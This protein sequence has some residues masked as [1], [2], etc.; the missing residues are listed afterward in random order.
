MK[1]LLQRVR[2][3]AVEVDGERIADIGAGIVCTAGT[4]ASPLEAV[5][6]AGYTVIGRPVLARSQHDV[7][8]FNTEI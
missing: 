2:N 6:K 1:V 4:G 8:C 3:A 7:R 5:S